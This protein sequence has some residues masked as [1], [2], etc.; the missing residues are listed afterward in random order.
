MR[1]RPPRRTR[2]PGFL[3]REAH[4]AAEAV[5]GGT[6]ET[7]NSRQAYIAMG[8]LLE[9]AALLEIDATPMEGFDAAQFNEILGLDDYSA[10]AVCAVGYRSEEKDWLASLPKV[11]FSTEEL[12]QR[13]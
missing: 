12:I 3:I 9:T 4:K 5:A 6:I 13:I 7:W 10:V 8:F 11:R 1:Q 2:A